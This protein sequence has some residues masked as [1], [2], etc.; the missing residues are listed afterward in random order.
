MDFL[1][2]HARIWTVLACDPDLRIRDIAHDIGTTGRA[3]QLITTDEEGR[4]A[5]A[6]RERGRAQSV[7]IRA[8]VTER[9]FL[10]RT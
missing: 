10:D 1:D 3:A 8:F 9:N 7:I 5:G 2:D 4:S 6:A